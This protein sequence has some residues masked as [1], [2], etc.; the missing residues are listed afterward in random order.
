MNPYKKEFCVYRTN[1]NSFFS[2]RLEI[3]IPFYT[4]K[5]RYKSRISVI[6]QILK[7]ENWY[8]TCVKMD[9]TENSW[10]LTQARRNNNNPLE[11]WVTEHWSWKHVVY[12][13]QNC[14]CDASKP[15]SWNNPEVE[16]LRWRLETGQT[17]LRK[18]KILSER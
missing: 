3:T 5:Q 2:L 18:G 4:K 9:S 8:G 14:T 7:T 12:I 16:T 6:Y 11:P 10:L 15:R 13:E 17:I 1:E